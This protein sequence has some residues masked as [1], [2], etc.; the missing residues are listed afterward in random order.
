MQNCKNA[1]RLRV[2]VADTFLTLFHIVFGL[3]EGLRMPFSLYLYE[4]L[5]SLMLAIY[6]ETRYSFFS[7]LS[8]RSMIC[9]RSIRFNCEIQRK[10]DIC[11]WDLL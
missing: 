11:V 10:S 3:S 8:R 4:L 2:K 9:L 5:S 6:K 7:K 1:I